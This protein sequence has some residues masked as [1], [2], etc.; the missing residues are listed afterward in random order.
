MILSLA[1]EIKRQKEL[2]G[3]SVVKLKLCVWYFSVFYQM[4]ALKNYEKCIL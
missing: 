4:K 2:A 3:T 1:M